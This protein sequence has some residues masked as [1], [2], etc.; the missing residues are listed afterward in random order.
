MNNDAFE[1]ELSTLFERRKAE[2]AV[3]E[4]T[5]DAAQ[6]SPKQRSLWAKFLGVFS[7]AGG[8]SFGVFAVITYLLPAMESPKQASQPHIPVMLDIPPAGNDEHVEK[9]VTTPALPPE[10]TTSRS[11]LPDAPQPQPVPTGQLVAVVPA[12]PELALSVNNDIAVGAMSAP[13]KLPNLTHKVM[14]NYPVDALRE[15]IGGIV[16]L[17]YEIDE[18]GHITDIALLSDRSH[19]MLVKSAK[20]ALQQWQ[21]EHGNVTRAEPLTVT[22]EFKLPEH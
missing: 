9:V 6:Q 5:L 4:I 12:V 14:P 3:P 8:M 21:Y 20:K 16:T 18:Q 2:L 22:F 11:D 13:P 19:S 17:S 15:E 7:I 10:P 1:Q